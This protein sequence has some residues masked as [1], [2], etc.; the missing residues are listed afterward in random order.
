MKY[1]K[2]L[3]PIMIAFAILGCSKVN[4]K[5]TAS[6]N[7]STQA[8]QTQASST[9]AQAGS[10]NPT[11]LTTATLQWLGLDKD[12]LSPNE[13]KADGKPDGHF[14]LT[15][16]FSQP[17]AVK[18]IWIRYSEFGKSLKWGWVYNKNLPRTGYM[19]AV[20]DSQGKLVVSQA[21]NGYRADGLTDFDLYISELNNENG[22]DTFKF[23]KDQTFSLEI[24]YV[25]QN[26]DQKEFD[27]SVKIS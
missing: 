14:H 3:V 5:S 12:Q 22:L 2:I 27:C 19:M 18:S 10:I 1:L 13:L 26:N 24:D 21:E 4:P 11:Q 6:T 7:T 25:T 16:P 15:V 8:P 9:Q 20:F 17:S 23:E